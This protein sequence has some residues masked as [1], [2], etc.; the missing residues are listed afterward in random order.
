MM[1]KRSSALDLPRG[2]ELL[3]HDV[4]DVGCMGLRDERALLVSKMPVVLDFSSSEASPG[5]GLTNAPRP[6]QLQDPYPSHASRSTGSS[7]VGCRSMSL[8]T[9]FSNR[10]TPI[11]RSPVKLG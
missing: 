3:T 8:S 10:M 1:G 7:A 11:I 6:F 5:R 9:V 4:L 2:F